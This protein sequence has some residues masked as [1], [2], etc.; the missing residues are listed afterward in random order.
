M[1]TLT[2][3]PAPSPVRFV[4][5]GW[6][7]ITGR[8]LNCM[9]TNRPHHK[10]GRCAPC[11]ESQRLA[12]DAKRDLFPSLND[13]LDERTPLEVL[14]ARS[15]VAAELAH[16]KTPPP[17]PIVAPV[18]RYAPFTPR[19][20]SK[21]YDW[22]VNCGHDDRE[23]KHSGLCLVCY[24]QSLL[25]RYTGNKGPSLGGALTD[26]QQRAKVD[27]YLATITR[28]V[29]AA[30]EPAAPPPPVAPSAEADDLDLPITRRTP[31]APDFL[32][33]VVAEAAR[34]AQD[35]TRLRAELTLTEARRDALT[36][37]LA[38]YA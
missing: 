17:A 19:Q 5:R 28:P 7:D 31:V 36:A 20:W 34:L 32:Q 22:C 6:E 21:H 4:C 27:A 13:V 8:H 18:D 10:D 35:A 14:A 24:P 9:T 23:A 16:R 3:P 12:H 26:A 29:V 38:A 2:A 1:T 11:S 25:T 30:A 37:L 33:Q 15:V